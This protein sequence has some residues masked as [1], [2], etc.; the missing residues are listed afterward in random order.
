MKSLE[1][2]AGIRSKTPVPIDCG[3]ILEA[4]D[5]TKAFDGLSPPK[6]FA[7][8]E[9][10]KKKNH[11]LFLDLLNAAKR[12]NALYFRAQYLQMTTREGGKLT[13]R[14]LDFIRDGFKRIQEV[15]IYFTSAKLGKDLYLAF[16]SD[17]L[18]PT[19][20]YSFNR[21][22]LDV[23]MK[24]EALRLDSTGF[25]Q[26]LGTYRKEML[27][28]HRATLGTKDPTGKRQSSGPLSTWKK[29][30][31]DGQTTLHDPVVVH[32]GLAFGVNLESVSENAYFEYFCAEFG[33]GAYIDS[34]SKNAPVGNT[35]VGTVR[36]IDGKYVFAY[37]ASSNHE[38]LESVTC[39]TAPKG[40]RR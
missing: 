32:D 35:P 5:L 20:I 23:V 30:H 31:G 18:E 17:L 4:S 19:D 13:D 10:L 24:N 21:E 38:R 2:R 8:S 39:R 6:Q 29:D 3:D 40:S 11:G 15:K 12:A 28:K 37:K 9:L 7:L 33:L 27:E 34:T 1:T 16:D 26:L 36:V 14:D 22:L 25:D